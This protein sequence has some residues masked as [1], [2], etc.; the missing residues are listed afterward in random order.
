MTVKE[1]ARPLKPR[2]CPSLVNFADKFIFVIAGC[3]PFD[4]REYL[5]SVDVYS[6]KTDSW[7]VAPA[8]NTPRMSHSSCVLKD[9]IYTF[10]G[11]NFDQGDLASIERLNVGD[12]SLDNNQY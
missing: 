11:T 5:D 8:L 10:C 7:A 4:H 12:V 6:I 2:S 9:T 1:K 3:N